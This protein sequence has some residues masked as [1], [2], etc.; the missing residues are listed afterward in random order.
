MQI[1]SFKVLSKVENIQNK[2]VKERGYYFV[3]NELFWK[4]W[5]IWS[6]WWYYKRS[7]IDTILVEPENSPL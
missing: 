6:F 2:I 1:T 5:R 3:V 4:N 7:H